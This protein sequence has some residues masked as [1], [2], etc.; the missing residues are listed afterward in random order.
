M[1]E[2]NFP[3]HPESFSAPIKVDPHRWPLFIGC[4][5]FPVIIY[6]VYGIVFLQLVFVPLKTVFSSYVS[7]IGSHE[8]LR[9]DASRSGDD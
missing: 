9:V 3:M 4:H 1:G 8:E 6:I 5:Y 7:T 2:F